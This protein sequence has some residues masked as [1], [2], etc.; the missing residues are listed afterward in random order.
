MA[1]SPINLA[2]LS[3]EVRSQFKAL[4]STP[5]IAWPTVSL[6]AIVT[7]VMI[8]SDFMA[9]T[10]QI[11][12]WAG[13]LIN[14]LVGYLA[15]SVVHDTIHRTAS[16]NTT[17]NDAIG[18]AAVMLFAPYVSHKLFRWGHI[19]HHRFASG[20]KDPDIVLQGAWWTLPFRWML[21]DALYLRHVLA[22][23]D[24]VSQQ[25]LRQSMWLMLGTLTIFG[26][27]IYA[28]YGME[29][30]MLWFIPSRLVFLMLGFTFFWLPHV[31]HDTTQEEN[32][33][34]ATTVR[35]GHE[36]LL[37][38]VLQ[39]QNFHLIH[40]LYPMTPFYNN[41]RVW[42]LLEPELRKKELAIQYGFAIHPTIHPAPK[43][44]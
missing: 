28:G 8:G 36:W 20:P 30:L 2:N 40:H 14:A 37:G 10:D 13:T 24:K 44:A 25:H 32:F 22:H 27:L 12:L 6:W 1:Q 21:I 16:A 7:V 29:L 18:Q 3:P 4:T 38:P 15:F 19:L 42:R 43:S 31:P 9:V 23:G 35:L 11:P 41:E 33:T 5:A 17:L 26:L 34:R 39:Y